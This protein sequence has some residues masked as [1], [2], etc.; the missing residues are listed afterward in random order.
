MKKTIPVLIAVLL[1]LVACGSK[2]DN[3]GAKKDD[4]GDMVKF[5]QCMRENGI[6]MPDPEDDGKGGVMMRAMPAD[7]A[8]GADGQ[9]GKFETAH[10]ACKQHLPNGGEFK[11][12]SP[13]EQDKIRQQAKCMRDKGHNWPDPEFDGNAKGQAIEMPDMD[14]EKIKQDMKDCGM[15]FQFAEAPAESK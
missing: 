9:A 10:N 7:E 11:P 4:T 3:G 15:D 14:D 5:A 8:G 6:D 12:P 2:Q 1:A 13:E